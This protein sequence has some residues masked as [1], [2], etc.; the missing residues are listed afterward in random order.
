MTQSDSTYAGRAH[1]WPVMPVMRATLSHL[2]FFVS[3]SL[4]VVVEWTG[5]DQDKVTGRVET[6]RRKRESACV[7]VGV[8]GARCAMPREKNERLAVK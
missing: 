3:F 2:G 7:R 6:V 8:K 5:W 1:T 4:I